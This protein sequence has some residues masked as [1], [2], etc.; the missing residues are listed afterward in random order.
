MERSLNRHFANSSIPTLLRATAIISCMLLAVAFSATAFA[1]TGYTGIFGGGPF[2][3]NAA[4]NIT[5]IEN[6]GFSE[7]IVW[8]VEV[9]SNGDLNFNGEFPLTS[10][11]VY[12]GNQTHPDF[13]ANMALLKQGMVKRVTFSIGSSNV[14]DWQDITALVKAQ[15]TGS[16]SILYKDFQALKAA[17]PALDALDFDDENSYD[18]PTTIAFG[19]MLGQLG[20]HVMPD[21]YTRSSYWTNVVAQINTQLPGTVDGVHLQ[22]YAGGQGNS[23][24][25]G[26]DFGSVPV[27]PGLWDRD[28]TPAQVESIMSAWHSQCGI[29][30]GFMWLYDDFVGNG[31]AAQYANAINTAVGAGGGGSFELSGPGNLFLNQNG[32]VGGTITI[33]RQNGFD[34]QIT[35]SLSQLPKGVKGGFKG[36]TDQRKIGFEANS[37]AATGLFPVT[38][39]GTSGEIKETT[40]FTLAVSAAVG[41]TGAGTQVDFSSDFDLY[42]IYQ[43]GMAYTTPGLDGLG[44]SYSANLLTA[45][46]VMNGVLFK[47][48][49]ANQPDAVSCSAQTID[50]P[51]GNFANFVLVGTGVNGNQASETITVHY[52]DGTST[53]VKQSFSDWFT[54]Q[55]YMREYEAVGMQYRNQANGT[56]DKRTFNLYAY[57]FPLNKSKAVQSITLPNDPSVA[58]LAGTL[59]KGK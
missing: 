12:V 4:N 33:T 51:Q 59:L 48:G 47:F 42:G 20:Y 32:K 55:N 6:S 16:D 49:P 36:Q 34:G 41:N 8:S 17:I 23:P 25:S 45:S 52:T 44:N 58:I 7:A 28:D 22:A 24:C 37:T 30:G 18:S 39:T 40:T 3:K 5:E 26:W 38:V 10:N 9:K 13:A 31:L 29:L 2:Y 53:A 57:L 43:D 21:P 35:L 15:G 46:R 56:K 54:P 14:G 1:Q 27:F 11:G 19:V 50:L